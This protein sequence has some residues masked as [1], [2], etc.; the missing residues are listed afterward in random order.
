MLRRTLLTLTAI[1]FLAVNNVK[2]VE[3]VKAIP[4]LPV[5]LRYITWSY[6]HPDSNIYYSL[7]I[8]TFSHNTISEL[9]APSKEGFNGLV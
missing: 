7:R 3:M 1:D 6:R 5:D 9:S 8:T 4:G 2:D